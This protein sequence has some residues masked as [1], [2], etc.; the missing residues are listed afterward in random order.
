MSIRIE[1]ERIT[2]PRFNVACQFGIC[3]ESAQ[4]LVNDKLYCHKHQQE[5][6]HLLRELETAM[7]GGK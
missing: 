5:I 1:V 7:K 6:V 4:W 3:C 2:S